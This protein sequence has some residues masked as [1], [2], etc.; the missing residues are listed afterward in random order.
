MVHH[1]SIRRALVVEDVI[2]QRRVWPIKK[3]KSKKP[4]A[5]QDDP[6][7]ASPHRACFGDRSRGASSG[8]AEQ[9]KDR[10]SR[11]RR[12]IVLSG[13][14]TDLASWVSRKEFEQDMKLGG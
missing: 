13:F 10:L 1:A 3:G 5:F 7:P 12:A 2:G 4:S 14:L 8:G 9:H 6:S 11:S